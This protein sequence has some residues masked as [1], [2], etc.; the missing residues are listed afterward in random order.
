MGQFAIF[1]DA[2]YFWKQVGYVLYGTHA[3]RRED[4]RID[5]MALHGQI[6]NVQAAQFAR[7]RLL[8]V[9]WY[10]S[11]PIQG[12]KS[13][14]HQAIEKLDDFKLRLGI[15]SGDH[16][17]KAV[18]GLIIADI[19]GLAQSKAIAGAILLSGDADLT[20]GVIAA[21]GLGIRVHLLSMEPKD[22]T[23][24]YLKAEV[25]CKVHWPDSIVHRFA[26]RS[27]N[28]AT[29]APADA[30]VAADTWQVLARKALDTIGNPANPVELTNNAIPQ[31]V[32]STLLRLGRQAVGRNLTEAEKRA[33][34]NAFKILLNPP[35]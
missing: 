19:I 20:P 16:K 34:R 14:S 24:G 32:D 6:L 35:A 27:A 22:A 17:Q 26:A 23:S 2:G 9:Y 33:L 12:G 21:Q 30:D 25:D 4:V 8:R 18:D 13:A 15:R 1:I 7:D 11:P 29:E 3:A 5:Y 31:E 10:D 28:P